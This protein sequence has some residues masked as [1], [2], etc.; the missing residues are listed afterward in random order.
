M[1]E[2]LKMKVRPK[3]TVVNRELTDMKSIFKDFSDKNQEDGK[4]VLT[5]KLAF[6]LESLKF[7]SGKVM[8]GLDD[9]ITSVKREIEQM[10]KTNLDKINE[11]MERFSF[12]EE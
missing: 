6:Y 3:M 7:D 8:G 1:F 5:K 11:L 4:P 9:E 12:S 2:E 10:N